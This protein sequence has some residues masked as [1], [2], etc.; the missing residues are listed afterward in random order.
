M[1]DEQ[2]EPR[3][4]AAEGAPGTAPGRGAG[5]AARPSV[6]VLA[7]VFVASLA[8][9]AAVLLVVVF[10]TGDRLQR[11]R[12]QGGPSDVRRPAA[13]APSAMLNRKPGGTGGVVPPRDALYDRLARMLSYLSATDLGAA[14]AGQE[15]FEEDENPELAERL[16]LAAQM[17]PINPAGQ[18]S[19]PPEDLELPA[20][21][22]LISVV[23]CGDQGGGLV[24]ARLPGRQ[25]DARDFF[26]NQAQRHGWPCTER[27]A[28]TP[29]TLTLLIEKGGAGRMITIRELASGAECLAAICDLGGE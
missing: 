7:L 20:N 23:P 21:A 5:P 15:D 29:G 19:E 14:K 2:Q 25:A 22:R 27:P 9:V 10:V 6:V 28:V 1:G 4:P 11:G 18:G 8:I 26:V 16:R 17:F 13:P 24:L 3:R 12:S